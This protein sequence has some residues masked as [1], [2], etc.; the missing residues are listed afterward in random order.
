V[1]ETALEAEHDEHLG[2]SKHAVEGNNSGNSQRHAGEDVLIDV[3]R[4]VPH[5]RERSFEPQIVKRGAA[6]AAGASGCVRTG[7]VSG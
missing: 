2:D 5:D 3:G 1:L 6:Q 4:D 7:D